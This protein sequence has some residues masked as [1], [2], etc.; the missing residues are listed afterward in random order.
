[1]AFLRLLESVGLGERTALLES[2]NVEQARRIFAYHGADP[3]NMSLEDLK[4]A[5]KKLVKRYHPDAEQGDVDAMKEINVAYE[6]LKTGQS[7]YGSISGDAVSD[8]TPAW[9]WAGHSGGQRPRG[10]INRNDYTD[11]NFFKK[12][13]WELSDKSREQWTIMQFDGHFFRH[14]ITVFGSPEIFS[15]MAE[16]MIM[17]GSHGGNPYSTEA[18]LVQ[19]VKDPMKVYIIYANAEFFDDAPIE[20]EHDSMNSNPSNDTG[21][22]RELVAKLKELKHGTAS[23]TAPAQQLP[24]PQ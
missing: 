8:E 11:M 19:R 17:W 13:M 12:R 6:T 23:L 7:S 9:A 22:V 15:D 16:A 14:S 5:Y 2:M 4:A 10:N 24:G 20:M 21:F 1:M 3:T 18:V